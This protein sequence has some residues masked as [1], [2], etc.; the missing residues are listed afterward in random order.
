MSMLLKGVSKLSGLEIDIGKD[1]AAQRIRNL[2]Q[3]VDNTDAMR[4]QDVL[5]LIGPQLDYFTNQVFYCADFE[6][7]LPTLTGSGSSSYNNYGSLA[8]ST[9]S[10]QN[11]TAIRSQ[12][13]RMGNIAGINWGYPFWIQFL[14]NFSTG[15]I[16]VTKYVY[17]KLA[18]EYSAADLSNKGV[19]IKLN[20]N[21]LALQGQVHN[22]SSRQTVNLGSLPFFNGT[23]GYNCSVFRIAFNPVAGRV[24]FY[25]IN[26]GVWSN[27][28]AIT[29][30]LPAGIDQS[31][32]SISISVSNP[33]TTE[34]QSAELN[35]VLLYKPYR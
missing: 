29:I 34:A 8:L 31:A 3:P 27:L 26:N 7:W 25:V 14:C 17:L 32:L 24:D 30:G 11:S 19:A 35:S 16:A 15:G 9:G 20:R 2:G 4:K 5:D 28:G 18:L 13:V 21:G 1:W 33:A 10:T 12:S 6:H 23:F 22:G